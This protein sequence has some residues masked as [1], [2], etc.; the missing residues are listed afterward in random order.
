MIRPQLKLLHAATVKLSR[1]L[2]QIHSLQFILVS[3]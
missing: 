3:T 2:S 1:A